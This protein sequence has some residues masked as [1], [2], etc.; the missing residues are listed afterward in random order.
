[1]T[2]QPTGLASQTQQLFV[3]DIISLSIR[4]V[5]TVPS[6]STNSTGSSYARNH[7]DNIIQ[8]A[9]QDGSFST[10]LITYLVASGSDELTNPTTIASVLAL[11]ATTDQPTTKPTGCTG[12]GP[13][14]GSGCGGDVGNGGRMMP[15]Q[16]AGGARGRAGCQRLHILVLVVVVVVSIFVQH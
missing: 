11:G 3:Q 13:R 4:T 12:T 7:V 10:S 6:N 5:Q 16:T 8:T 9:K 2:T 14:I 15:R 1:M